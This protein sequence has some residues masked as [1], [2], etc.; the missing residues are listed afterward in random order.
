MIGMA[1]L[2][3]LALGAAADLDPLHA[4]LEQAR[5]QAAA[6]RALTREERENLRALAV[7]ASPTLAS[8]LEAA[9]RRPAARPQDLASDLE[10]LAERANAMRNGSAPLPAGDARRQRQA[11]EEV[12]ARREYAA[13][14]RDPAK[15]DAT[16]AV[17][18]WLERLLERLMRWLERL[19]RKQAVAPGFGFGIG[20]AAVAFAVLAL[21]L[22]LVAAVAYRWASERRPAA[23]APAAR[24]GSGREG[25]E[26]LERAPEEWLR[27]A[28]ELFGRGETG[29]AIR[30]LYLAL[31][32]SLHR[33][34]AIEVRPA[35]TNWEHARRVAKRLPA[36]AAQFRDLTQEFDRV[37]YGGRPASAASYRQAREQ[38]RSVLETVR[39]AATVTATL[40]GGV[41]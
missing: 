6:G 3:A 25:A 15:A 11:L 35:R 29:A 20:S 40:P 24:G 36:A 28:E 10:R 7:A 16:L 26:A 30:A 17:P 18:G 13:V 27:L 5:G 8:E 31:L 39:G 23:P 38:A 32:V 14:H 34:G 4:G 41:P 22:A 19:E 21:V 12:L 33:A 37:V 1:A 9:L 2:V